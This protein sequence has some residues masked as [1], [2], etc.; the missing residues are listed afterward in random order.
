[1]SLKL[2][3]HPLASFCQKVLIALYENDTPFEPQVVD[4]MDAAD[5]AAFRKIW[6]IGKFPVLRDEA[7]GRTVPESTMIIEYLAA[8]F[9]SRTQLLPADPVLLREVRERDRFFDLYVN[10]PIQKIV[11]DRI[12]PAGAN[13]PYG[14]DEA[15]ALL[16][17]ALRLTDEHMAGRTWAAGETFTMA[18]CAAAPALFYA[19]LV[20]P[21]QR[22]HRNATAYLDRLKQ[23]ASYAR[24]LRE[25]EPY[26]KMFPQ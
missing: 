25:A 20:M 5:A 26:L 7:K 22:T 3:L 9:P 24:V 19:D 1:M 6:P 14:V 10:A 4:L 15:R 17:T 13:D 8:Q 18:D 11:T 21:F 23:R 2:Y 16:E 12:R